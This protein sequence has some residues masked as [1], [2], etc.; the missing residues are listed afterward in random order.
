MK[1]SPAVSYTHL[2]QAGPTKTPRCRIVRLRKRAKDGRLPG[3][4][5]ADTGVANGKTQEG[6]LGPCLVD[7]D[8]DLNLSALGELDRVANEIAEYLTQAR[9]VANYPARN[10][11]SCLLYTS[12]LSTISPPLNLAEIS[13]PSGSYLNWKILCQ[14]GWCRVAGRAWP[15][16]G[17]QARKGR[18]A[19]G[20][21]AK[22]SGDDR[23]SGGCPVC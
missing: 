1:P 16:Q 13:L 19:R 15:P 6:R 18:V 12:S 4:R 10:I 8:G 9:G 2:A 11:R 5:N 3:R 21:E 20:V 7:R 22:D 17:K 14:A 23:L